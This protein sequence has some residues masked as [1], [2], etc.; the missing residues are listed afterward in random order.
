MKTAPPISSPEEPA[1]RAQRYRDALLKGAGKRGYTVE[2]NNFNIHG[3]RID[4]H[5]YER[6]VRRK[7]PLTKKELK[8]WEHYSIGKRGWKEVREPSGWLT[9]GFSIE[10]RREIRILEQQNDPLDIERIL[11]RFE[12]MAAEIAAESKRRYEEEQRKEK[13]AAERA[14]S[15]EVEEGR[16]EAMHDMLDDIAKAERLRRLINRVAAQSPLRPDQARR[17]KKWVR[18]ATAHA[19][20]IDPIA[21]DFDIVLSRLGMPRR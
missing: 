12:K 9:F 8:T 1:V 7:A 2:G 15:R 10:R 17:V 14:T 5:F 19:N 18:W 21:T 3:C 6:D 11:N 13:R 4:W 20:A 16:W